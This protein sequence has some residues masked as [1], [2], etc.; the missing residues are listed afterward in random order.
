[1]SGKA[2]KYARE[3]MTE[4]CKE[5]EKRAK[6]QKIFVTDPNMGVTSLHFSS[7]SSRV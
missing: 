6:T 5:P 7:N 4:N 1:V 2:T 3:N